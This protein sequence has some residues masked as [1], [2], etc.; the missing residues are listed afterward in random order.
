MAILCVNIDHVTTLRQAR[1]GVEP[2]PIAAALL[3]ESA[4]AMGITVHLREDRR[5]IQDR[6][7]QLLREIVRT[8]LNL[9]MATVDSIVNIALVLRPDQATLVPERRQEVTTEG[10]LDVEEHQEAVRAAVSRLQAA[11][12]P[13]SLFID[14]DEGQVEASA[15]TGARMVELH[16]GRYSVAFDSRDP[17]SIHTEID[18]L[19]AAAAKARKLGMI[20]NAGHGLNIWNVAPVAAIPD[21]HELNI[22]HSIM[23][24]AIL[25][26]MEC[27]VREM[28]EAIERAARK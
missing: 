28:I 1:G 13:T 21:M 6:D 17:E 3:C 25:I 11:G 12:I 9:E 8:P 27:A 22:G 10:G 18:A 26:G 23:S 2:D 4:G 14:P 7:V 19:Y 16:T 5:H 24:R 15:Q 20:V